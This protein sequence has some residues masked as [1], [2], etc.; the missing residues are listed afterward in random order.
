MLMIRVVAYASRSLNKPEKNYCTIEKE[1]LA[2]VWAVK[3]FRPY[4]F[5]KKFKIFTDHK[6]LIYLFG[7]TNPSSRLTKFRIILEEYDFEIQYIKG[8]DNVVADALSRITSD[9]LK[10]LNNKTCYVMT[11]SKTKTLKETQSKPLTTEERID[12]PGFVGVLN[13]SIHSIE[14]QPI[15]EHEFDLMSL[16]KKINVDKWKNVIYDIK[17]RT[18]YVHQRSLA[19]TNSAA[20]MKDLCDICYNMK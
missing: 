10:E 5:G 1:L 4:L 18:I 15:N 13:R 14:L 7:M 11:R 20:W 12:H 19:S 9:E 8:K 3:H 17:M 6:P 16:N 2:I